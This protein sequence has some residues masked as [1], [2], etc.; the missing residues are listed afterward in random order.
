MI[1]INFIDLIFAPT[2][3][4]LLSVVRVYGVLEVCGMKEVGGIL[5]QS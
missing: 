5:D 4:T 3:C 1:Q 2:K